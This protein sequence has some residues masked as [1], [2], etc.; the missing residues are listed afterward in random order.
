MFQTNFVSK[1]Y[2][3]IDWFYYNQS[4]QFHEIM[5]CKVS[6]RTLVCT[7]SIDFD[8]LKEQNLSTQDLYQFCVDLAQELELTLLFECV[9]PLQL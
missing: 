8:R 7:P 6:E 3:T 1:S 4:W 2:Y 9:D 5:S